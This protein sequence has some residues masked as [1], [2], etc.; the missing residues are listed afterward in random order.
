LKNFLS[1]RFGQ[2]RRLFCI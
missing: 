2:S 1:R